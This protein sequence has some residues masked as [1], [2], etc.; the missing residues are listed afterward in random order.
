MM[1]MIYA[2]HGPS[3]GKDGI[4]MGVVVIFLNL[5]LIVLLNCLYDC[6]FTKNSDEGPMSSFRVERTWSSL[7]TCQTGFHLTLMKRG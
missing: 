6:T 5:A 4:D 7:T 1:N 2:S 3:G